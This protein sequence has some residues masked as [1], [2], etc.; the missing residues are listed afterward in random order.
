MRSVG[1][2]YGALT[3]LQSSESLFHFVEREAPAHEEQ[4][5]RDGFAWD[6]LPAFPGGDAAGGLRVAEVAVT[7]VMCAATVAVWVIVRRTVR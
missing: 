5:G 6:F 2:P 3:P 1:F 7:A 4:P